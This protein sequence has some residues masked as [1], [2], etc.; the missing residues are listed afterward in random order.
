TPRPC[1]RRLAADPPSP[2]RRYR[3]RRHGVM[4]LCPPECGHGPL[5]PERA[6]CLSHP[7][8]LLW[9]LHGWLVPHGSLVAAVPGDDGGHGIDRGVLDT[10]LRLAR[11]RRLPGVAGR[12]PPGAA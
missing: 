12:P 1:D 6:H 11:K 5:G 7:R 10:A 8:R 4:G 2:C 9:V 3:Y